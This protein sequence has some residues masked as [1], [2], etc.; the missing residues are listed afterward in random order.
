MTKRFLA[1]GDGCGNRTGLSNKVPTIQY[2]CAF[3]GCLPPVICNVMKE[4]CNNKQ[5]IY[6][7]L[8]SSVNSSVEVVTRTVLPRYYC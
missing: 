1:T 5:T 6:K 4:H 7:S 2:G 3:A 8:P